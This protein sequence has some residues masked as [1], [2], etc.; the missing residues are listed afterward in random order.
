MYISLAHCFDHLEVLGN[1]YTTVNMLVRANNFGKSLVASL[2]V[3]FDSQ[4][5]LK[6]DIIS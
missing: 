3:Y 5:V 2:E 1:L 4:S 6:P